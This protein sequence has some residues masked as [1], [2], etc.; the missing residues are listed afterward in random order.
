MRKLFLFLL[1]TLFISESYAVNGWFALSVPI[2]YISDIQFINSQTG[3]ITGLYGK[4]AKTT[5][6]G[7]TWTAFTIGDSTISLGSINFINENTGWMNGNQPNGFPI[8]PNRNY[9]YSTT[10][11]GVNWTVRSQSDGDVSSCDIYMTG[12]DSLVVAS[13]GFSDFGS[14]GGLSYSFNGGTLF[15]PAIVNT[16]GAQFYGLQFLNNITG[17]VVSCYDSDTGP[18]YNRIYK[19]T[20]SGANWNPIYKDSVQP[21]RLLGCFFVNS[22]KGYLWARNSKLAVTTNSGANWNFINTPIYSQINSMHFFDENT[23]Y[24]GFT[25]NSQDTMGLKRTTDGGFTWITM[26]NSLLKGISRIIFVDNLTGWAT[27]YSSNGVKLMKTV[28]GGLTSVN[29]IGNVVPDKFSLSQN[30]PNPFN[31]ITK[32]NYELPITNF[33]SLKVYDALGNEVQT[34]VNQK[35]NAGSYSVDFNAASLPSGIYFYK[36]VTE[37]FSETKKMILVK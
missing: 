34:L 36:L 28:T 1:L 14:V 12:K 10:N 23:G 35:Q 13:L 6:G 17:Y 9:M 32:I 3:F 19:T 30:Y 27:G 4:Y 31:P 7:Q 21:P 11:G 37:K 18:Y 22:N 33:V 29:S 5:D 20:N 2:P 26:T 15:N 25:F 24:A 16:N 8:W